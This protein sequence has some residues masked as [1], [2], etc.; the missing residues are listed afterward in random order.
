MCALNLTHQYVRETQT[1]NKEAVISGLSSF[2]R[3]INMD[4]KRLFLGDE[5]AGF[6]FLREALRDAGGQ[7]RLSKKLVLLI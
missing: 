1:K 6:C 5:Y 7:V 4:G 3:G 2:L